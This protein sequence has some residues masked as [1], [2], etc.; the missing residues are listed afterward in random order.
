MRVPRDPKMVDKLAD[1][2]HDDFERDYRNNREL[3]D[4][5]KREKEPIH[6]TAERDY[7]ARRGVR[8][9]PDSA[10]KRAWVDRVVQAR[11]ANSCRT[12]WRGT[13][14][15]RPASNLV[16]SRKRIIS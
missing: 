11:R 14:D 3:Y 16:V 15:C 2:I 7:L 10:G 12:I 1:K 6:Y 9:R 4:S 5:G 8:S 13:N